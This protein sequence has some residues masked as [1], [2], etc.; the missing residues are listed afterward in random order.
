[1]IFNRSTHDMYQPD[2]R[3]RKPRKQRV[4]ILPKPLPS[5]ASLEEKTAWMR[6]RQKMKGNK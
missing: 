4:S 1:M 3:A 5:G 6:A 2:K